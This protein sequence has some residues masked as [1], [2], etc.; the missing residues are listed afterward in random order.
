MDSCK[1]RLWCGL[2]NGRLVVYDV[3]TLTHVECNLSAAGS[4]VRITAGSTQQ[5]A[6]LLYRNY[7]VVVC[8][9]NWSL[10]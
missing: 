9:C 7:D 6:S 10:I 8:S 2:T 5:R 4:I 1:P 3:E